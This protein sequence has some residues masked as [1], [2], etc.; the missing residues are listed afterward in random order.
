MHDMHLRL[1]FQRDSR[2]ESS[3][4]AIETY[5][6]LRFATT[7][8]SVLSPPVMSPQT[9]RQWAMTSKL[10]LDVH[11]REQK[12]KITYIQKLFRG[13]KTRESIKAQFGVS[14]PGKVQ[15]LFTKLQARYRGHIVRKAMKTKKREIDARQ[16]PP[17]CSIVSLVGS[18]YYHPILG[19]H[20]SI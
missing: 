11:H 4:N 5:P 12:R 7:T 3:F 8:F 15:R 1:T 10:L 9:R 2:H 20:H 19:R 13:H 17:L 16:T 6:Q 14:N 18:M